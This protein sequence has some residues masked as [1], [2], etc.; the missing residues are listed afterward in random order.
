MS[1]NRGGVRPSRE[2]LLS[3]V[4][5][6]ER[7]QWKH[8]IRRHLTVDWIGGVNTTYVICQV[9]SNLQKF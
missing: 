1:A 4:K 2:K 6:S 7:Y 9:K 5:A 8:V 3:L